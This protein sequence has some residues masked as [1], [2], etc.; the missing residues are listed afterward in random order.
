[1]FEL[2]LV[3]CGNIIVKTLI[4]G[5]VVFGTGSVAHGL[6][7]VQAPWFPDSNTR[8]A[9]AEVAPGSTSSSAPPVA[10]TTPAGPATGEANEVS[11]AHDEASTITI[12]ES[13]PGLESTSST[14][15]TS[16]TADTTSSTSTSTT[17]TTTPETTAPETTTPETTTPETTAPET[18]APGAPGATQTTYTV[19]DAG[20]VTISYSAAGAS[21]V[22]VSANAGWVATIEHDEPGEAD[23]KFE[24]GEDRV[25]FDAEIDDGALRIR[26]RDR[27][28]EDLHDDDDS[29][30]DSDDG[31]DNDSDDDDSDDDSST[32]TSSTVP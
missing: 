24:M 21:V 20:T 10:T 31:S 25:D 4:G 29:D 18:T 12:V 14:S 17:S 26:I 8:V 9:T 11:A 16:T 19:L 32:T 3:W 5:S 28:L 1:M 30:D 27:R 22:S 13:V 23:V 15:S 6:G 2:M 7:I